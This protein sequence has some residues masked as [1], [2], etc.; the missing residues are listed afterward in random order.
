MAE[1]TWSDRSENDLEAIYHNVSHDSVRAAA[2]LIEQIAGAAGRLSEFPLSGRM[3][4]EFNRADIREIIVGNFRVVHVV[5]GDSVGVA[6]VH[7]GA[8]RLRK[9]DLK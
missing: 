1:L 6:L 9:S 3:V 8:R 2:H 5:S 7:H 4:P